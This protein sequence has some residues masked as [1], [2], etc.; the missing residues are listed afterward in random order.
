MDLK[1]RYMIAIG[2]YFPSMHHTV[3]HELLSAFGDANHERGFDFGEKRHILTSG[4]QSTHLIG[5]HDAP[6][7]R[8]KVSES[9][10]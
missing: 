8:W 4:Y 3:H 7:F 5:I 2:P 10:I 6:G 1:L 9:G